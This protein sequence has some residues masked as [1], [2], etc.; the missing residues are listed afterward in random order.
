MHIAGRLRS[1]ASDFEDVTRHMAQQA[2]GKV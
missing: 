2:F 1:G